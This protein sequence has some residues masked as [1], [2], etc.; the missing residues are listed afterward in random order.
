MMS[1][2]WGKKLTR[3]MDVVLARLEASRDD[4]S[5]TDLATLTNRNVPATTGAPR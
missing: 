2:G 5:T 1:N 4:V 3:Y